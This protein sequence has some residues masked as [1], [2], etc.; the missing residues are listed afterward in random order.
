[1][2]ALVDRTD[3]IDFQSKDLQSASENAVKLFDDIESTIYNLG[4]K[5]VLHPYSMAVFSRKLRVTKCP[6]SASPTLERQD[7]ILINTGQYRLTGTSGFTS[8]SSHLFNAK[9]ILDRFVGFSQK[10]MMPR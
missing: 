5:Y 3:E 7:Q 6:S 9:A 8:N 4:L 10:N 1:M 2:L